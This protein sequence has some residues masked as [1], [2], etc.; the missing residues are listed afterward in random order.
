M[1]EIAE[2]PD[3]PDYRGACITN[4]VPS[5][6]GPVAP[7]APWFP[8]ALG[9]ARQV[10]LLVLDGLGW[11]QLQDRLAL[12]PTMASLDGGPI[13]TVA[14]STTSSALTSITTG[15]TPAEHGIVG[16]RIAERSDVLN[17]LRWSTPRGDARRELPPDSY[18]PH[19]PF[20]GQRPPI[21]TRADFNGSGFTKAHL[22][23]ARQHS[24]RVPS[25]MLT[26]IR[27]LL[28][29][30][31]SFIYAYYEGIDKVA[32]EY[33]LGEYYDAE[34]QWVDNFVAEILG[35]LPPDAV[36]A[37]TAD[38]G[39]V[40]VGDNVI[41]LQDDVLR[42]VSMQSGEGRFRWL[43]AR[44]GHARHLAEAA[45]SLGDV[46]W[47]K[48]QEEIVAEGWFG[49]MISDDVRARLGDVALVARA[50]VSFHDPADSGPFNL[51]GRHGSLT[52]AE[53]RVPLLVSSL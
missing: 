20:L 42:H 30:G 21:V 45:A 9:T 29:N 39:Q 46:A 40:D 3:L 19:D 15:L 24:Y 50:D 6:L 51:I 25:T 2:H 17:V 23:G 11:L 41:V 47:V 38:H 12:A 26:E 27:R 5:L 52:P 16:Y 48:T 14:P 37:I 22:R 13:H 7:D 36:L 53:M 32:H 28:L 4:I 33:G 35:L 34:L 31:E 43:H 10:V 18:Q 8:S 1:A 49:P 44:S